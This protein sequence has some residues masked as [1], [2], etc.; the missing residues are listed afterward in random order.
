MKQ[1]LRELAD[2]KLV[3]RKVYQEVSLKVE[4]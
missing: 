1:T 3:N 4:Y 2:D